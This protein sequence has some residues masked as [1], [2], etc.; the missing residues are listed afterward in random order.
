MAEANV[1]C[2]FSTTNREQALTDI[3]Y[4]LEHDGFEPFASCLED[5]FKGF[6][7]CL[8]DTNVDTLLICYQALI[9]SLPDVL[10]ADAIEREFV[11]L[12]PS[13]IENLG[14]QKTV[15]RKSTHRCIASYVKLSLKLEL[16]LDHIVSVGLA[17]SKHR[18]RQHSMLVVPALLSLKKGCVKSKDRHVVDLLEAVA[19]KLSDSSEIVQKTAK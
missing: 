4:T 17:H 15:V 2:L 13:L 10:K 6:Q 18:T 7:A 12:L 8:T 3:K 1:Q 5:L 14:S 11:K 16:V 9:G 19:A